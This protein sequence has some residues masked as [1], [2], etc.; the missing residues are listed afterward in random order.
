MSGEVGWARLGGKSAVG[1]QGV[2]ERCSSPSDVPPSRGGTV[3]WWGSSLG[4]GEL[5][6]A[7][8]ANGV[9][10]RRLWGAH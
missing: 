9:M 4:C 10:P 5:G 7:G 6:A 3:G 1:V 8:G 2:E